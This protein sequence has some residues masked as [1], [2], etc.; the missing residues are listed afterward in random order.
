MTYD[1][2][3]PGWACID[4]LILLANGDGPQDMTDDD[5]SDYDR[6]VSETFSQYEVT[7]GH[8][9]A[10]HTGYECPRKGGWDKWD[11]D[12]ED[13]IPVPG[14]PDDECDCEIRPF[15]T[16]G[17]DVCESPLAGEMHAVTFWPLTD[18]ASTERGDTL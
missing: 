3:S 7:L 13:W 4:C 9:T 18:H 5:L 6:R 15:A 12:L 2:R 10:D 11:D 1:N 17:C 14:D 16:G 8:V